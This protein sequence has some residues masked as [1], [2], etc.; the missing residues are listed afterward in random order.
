MGSFMEV[1]QAVTAES[2]SHDRVVTSASKSSIRRFVIT[3][4]AFPWLKAAT[5]AFTFKTQLRHYAKQALTPTTVRL[6][7]AEVAQHPHVCP[8]HK[9]QYILYF[10]SYLFH[11]I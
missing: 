1:L 4:K 2:M 10:C 8:I 3:E 7:T 11:L 6:T 9:L 5:T